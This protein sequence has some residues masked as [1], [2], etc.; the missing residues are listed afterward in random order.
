MRLAGCR[1]KPPSGR[2]PE[3]VAAAVQTDNTP[4]P[5]PIKTGIAGRK[6]GATGFEAGSHPRWLAGI[7][8]AGLEAQM[9]KN[10]PPPPPPF[11]AEAAGRIG[12]LV[13]S[14][15]LAYHPKFGWHQSA[16]P[17]RSTS[18]VG[19]EGEAASCAESGLLGRASDNSDALEWAKSVQ[20]WR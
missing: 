7:L 11:Q 3:K 10:L 12:K 13:M 2:S 20:P 18:K 1:P 14:G 15:E 16:P 5:A 6:T 19:P 8:N 9:S 17:R 4:P